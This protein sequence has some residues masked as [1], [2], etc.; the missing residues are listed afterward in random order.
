MRLIFFRKI[1]FGMIVGALVSL[2]LLLIFSLILSGQDDPSKLM[3]AFS[4]IS[5]IAGSIAC[6]K[7]ATLGLEA[8]APQGAATGVAFALLVLLPSVI[9]SDFSAFSIL[10]MLLVVVL[11]FAG[12]MLGTKNARNLRSSKKRKNVVKRYAR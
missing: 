7:A 8:K 1:F 11:T 6:G 10:K 4:L 2:V 9:L 5:L 3:T 12:A